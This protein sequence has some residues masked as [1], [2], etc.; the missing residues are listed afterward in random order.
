MKSHNVELD[1]GGLR[2][3]GRPFAMRSGELHPAR[4]PPEYW[5]HRIRMV[6]ALGLNTVAAYVFWNRHE[7]PDGRLDFETGGRRIGDFIDLVAEEGLFLFL[8]PGP[9]VCAE[10]D[11]GGLPSRLLRERGAGLRCMDPAYLEAAGAYLRALAEIIRPR[12]AKNGGPVILVQVENEYGSYGS[13]RRYLEW[14]RRAWVEAGV[15]GSFC[16]ADGQSMP[17]IACGSLP[18]CAVGVDGGLGAAELER[19]GRAAPGM[20]A[21]IAELYPGWLTHWGERAAKSRDCGKTVEDCIRTGRSFNLYVVHGGTN[22]GLGA[23]AN[24]FARNLAGLRGERFLPTITSYDY[25]APIDE[26]GRPTKGYH[27]LRARIAAATG[28]EP[29]DLPEPV[30]AGELGPIT[31]SR[32]AGFRELLGPPIRAPEPLAF[33]DFGQDQGLA[34]YRVRLPHAE[35]GKL[36]IH[37]LHDYGIAFLDG[38]EIGV[39]DRRKG[40]DSLRIPKVGGGANKPRI[41]EGPLLEILVEAMGHVNFGELMGDRKGIT[42]RVML[43]WIRLMDWEILPLPL[44]EGSAPRVGSHNASQAGS[45]LPDAVAATG[46]GLHAGCFRLERPVDTFIDLGR[47]GKGYAWV[48]G[49]LLGRYWEI[50]PQRR[51]Y[52]PAPFLRAGAN[53]LA[54]LEFRRGDPRPIRGY[55]EAR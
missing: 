33:E 9:Y 18:G 27:A 53:E 37:G 5:R 32:R 38:R 24:A 50:G 28:S 25:A 23:G 26:Q 13:D 29:P 20:P 41:C 51:L 1:A 8:R 36:R 12:L 49:R 7:R 47:W 30:P 43:D 22:F 21:F 15:E 10:W 3:D 31:L 44:D 48:N 55:P 2:L 34:L 4:I 54:L 19:A 6:K 35:G 42:G 11:L 52:C 45:A 46:A 39:L 14:V 17:H 40:R 16:T